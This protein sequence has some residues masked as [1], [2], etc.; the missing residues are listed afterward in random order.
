MTRIYAGI[1]SR[2]TPQDVLSRMTAIADKRAVHGWVLRSGAA[3]GADAA[4]ER[5][6]V[7]AGG[8]TEIYLPF[9]RFRGHRSGTVASTLPNWHD[10]L[11]IAASHHPA[12][13]RCS[14]VARQL[15]ARN[16][17]QILGPDLQAPVEDVLFFAPSTTARDG[18][19]VDASGGTG[20]AIRLAATL[21]IPVR[22]LAPF[23]RFCSGI[24]D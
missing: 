9:P 1:G 3:D 11:A 20:L 21:S 15:L 18:R 6:A 14:P 24:K 22:Y 19:I 13:E 4:F 10:A 5:G 8:Q 2:Q 17:F 16:V 7:S 23:P 12:W